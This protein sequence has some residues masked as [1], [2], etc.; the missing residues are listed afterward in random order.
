MEIIARRYIIQEKLGEG[1]MWEVYRVYDRLTR[2]EV[3]L[4]RVNLT[5]NQYDHFSQEMSHDERRAL[6]EEFRTLASLRH[7]HIISVLDYGFDDNRQ[8]FLTMTLLKD[9][10]TL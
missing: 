8:P 7:P 3:A 2:E 10:Q 9:G 5:P 1:A 6:A 4:K